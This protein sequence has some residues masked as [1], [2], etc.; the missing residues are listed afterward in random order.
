MKNFL[1]ILLAVIA[2]LFIAVVVLFYFQGDKIAALAVEKTIPYI[3]DSII[4]NLP[5]EVDKQQAED[6]FAKLT[7]KIKTGN[8]DKVELQKMMQTFQKYMEDKK[9]NADEAKELLQM[10]EK[11]SGQ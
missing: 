3:K 11:I 7:Q 4:Q 9:I 2:I 6:A 1:L 5:Q 8:F 10:V